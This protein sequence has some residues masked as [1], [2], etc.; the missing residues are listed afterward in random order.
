MRGV[1]DRFEDL[2]QAVILIEDIQ[3]AIVVPVNELPK[4]SKENTYFWIEE[5]NGKYKVK[6]IDY[7]K[8]KREAER[9]EELMKKLQAKSRDSKFRKN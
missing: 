9:S 2:N 6:S 7:K 1:L 4:G 8:T 3:I 5:R